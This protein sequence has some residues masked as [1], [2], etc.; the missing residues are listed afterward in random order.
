MR[1]KILLC[2]NLV[3]INES[4]SKN[5]PSVSILATVLSN[6]T[7]FGYIL[8]KDAYN[9]LSGLPDDQIQSWWSCMEPVMKDITGD[10][11]QMDKYVVYKNF[12]REVLEKSEA[13]YWISQILMYWGLPNHLFTE[14][15]SDFT[16][17][18][19]KITRIMTTNPYII[20]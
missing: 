13:E 14:L 19:S 10:S 5:H 18:F 8:S 4:K 2:N 11:N 17:I 20:S 6:I 1:E 7:Y 15:T 16:F 3:E 9:R 12:P